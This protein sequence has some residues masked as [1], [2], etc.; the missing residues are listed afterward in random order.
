VASF[1]C[2]ISN[3]PARYLEDERVKVK[4]SAFEEDQVWLTW[5]DLFLLM[6]GRELREPFT[7]MVIRRGQPKP[8][9]IR[10]IYLRGD[11]PKYDL[12]AIYADIKRPKP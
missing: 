11:P 9:I 1:G 7:A 10:E 3:S 2:T 4:H 5:K 6:L 8:M 12:N